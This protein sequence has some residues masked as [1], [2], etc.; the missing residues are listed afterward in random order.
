MLTAVWHGLFLMLNS[1]TNVFH[2]LRLFRDIW[3]AFKV[4]V[5]FIFGHL[6]LLTLI[7]SSDLEDYIYNL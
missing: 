5:L 4:S 1:E 2:P 3:A 6:S 7:F